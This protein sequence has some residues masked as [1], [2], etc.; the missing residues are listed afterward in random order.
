MINHRSLSKPPHQ[1]SPPPPPPPAP[2]HHLVRL[3]VPFEVM[4]HHFHLILNMSV[5]YKSNKLL[6]E[7]K[8]KQKR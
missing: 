7:L 1:R 2:P 6:Q 4:Y 3:K 5:F 8:S